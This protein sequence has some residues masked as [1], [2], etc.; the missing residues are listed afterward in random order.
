MP[1]P[2]SPGR[3]T[4]HC[5][6][7]STR[8]V[9]ICTLEPLES[10]GGRG[11]REGRGGRGEEGGGGCSDSNPQRVYWSS[12]E[13]AQVSLG[14]W[15]SCERGKNVLQNELPVLLV[16]RED[17]WGGPTSNMNSQW[18]TASP[19][20]GLT[21]LTRRRALSCRALTFSTKNGKVPREDICREGEGVA[22]QQRERGGCAAPAAQWCR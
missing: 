22:E 6:S 21:A 4:I 20:A 19:H 10:L 5:T 2:W 8:A 12:L 13:A 14:G 15:Q 17:L 7:C 11:G 18:C 1:Q 9:T 3:T 16:A